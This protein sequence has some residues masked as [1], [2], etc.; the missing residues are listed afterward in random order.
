MEKEKILIVED[1]IPLRD[2]Y[3]ARLEME[4]YEVE[5]AYD[6]EEGLSKTIKEKP[7]LIILDLMMP[8]ISGLDFLDILKTTP[9]TKNIPVIVLTALTNDKKKAIDSGAEDYLIK[10]ECKLEE[11]LAKI[12]EVL[13]KYKK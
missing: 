11:V 4:G 9:S 7:N 12:K 10:S 8:K 1:D 13:K 5:V 3:Q 2:M 6:G